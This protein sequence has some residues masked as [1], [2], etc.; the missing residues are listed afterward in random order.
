[1]S[2]SAGHR[3]WT[4]RPCPLN[5]WCLF[6]LMQG[7]VNTLK[8]KLFVYNLIRDDGKMNVW[9]KVFDSMIIFL[10]SVNT[11]LVILETFN[12]PSHITSLFNA[13]EMISVIIFSIE[14][15]MRIWVADFLHPNDGKVRSRLKYIFSGM[16]IIDL[17]AILPFYLPFLF[18]IDLR[19]LRTFRLF[20]LFRL[21][22][23]NRY[24][25]AFSNIS[26]VI[27][28]KSTQLLSSLFVVLLLMIISSIL[29]YSIEN[30]QQPDVFKNAFSG[31]WWTLNTITT[32]GYGDIYPV[33]T[34]GRI[35]SG[36]IAVLG[37]GL[38]A[39]PTGIISAGFVEATETKALHK[40]RLKMICDELLLLDDLRDKGVIT[41]EEY[42]SQRNRILEL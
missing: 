4:C 24:T 16:A 2:E 30:P 17:L 39:V 26:T 41:Q 14:Y 32:V 22:K 11:L 6:E 9:S 7:E 27:K 35:L 33:T 15:L 18:R 19:V 40:Y 31:F 20:R 34:A 28:S 13:V 10:I 38:V 23:L 29:M 21:L 25:S 5:L 8:L 3:C 42:D 1:M 37:I 12:M 36:V